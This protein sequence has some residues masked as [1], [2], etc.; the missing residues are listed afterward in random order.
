MVI[1]KI[2][3]AVLA[4]FLISFVSAMTCSTNLIER[5]V[6]VGTNPESAT[7]TCINANYSTTVNKI[8]NFFSLVPT[9]PFLS[10]ANAN[11][12]IQINFNSGLTQNVYEGMIFFSDSSSPVTIKVNVSQPPQNPSGIIVFPTTKF[13]NIKQGEQKPQNIQLIVPSNYGKILTIHSVTMNPEISLINFG[14][15]NLGQVSPG[16]TLNLGF[17][18]DA[19]DFQTGVYNTQINI[20]ATDNEGQVQLPL[21]NVQILVSASLN[22]ITNDTFAQ[23]PVCSLSAV[24]MNVN[25]TYLFTCNN[26]VNNLDI[27][28]KYNEYFEG[29]SSDLSSG[30]YSYKF[31]PIKYGTTKFEAVFLYRNSPIFSAYT[32]EVSISSSGASIP[33]TNLKLL[34][35]PNLSIAKNNQQV[36]IQIIDNRSGSLVNSPELYINA[37]PVNNSISNSFYFNFKVGQ[38]YSIRARSPGYDDFVE[39][40]RLSEKLMT[41]NINPKEGDADTIFNITS[42]V[43]NSTLLLNG[44][45]INNPYYS[46]LPSGNNII[47]AVKEGY[48]DTNIT[49][50]IAPALFLTSLNEFK[51]GLEQTFTLSKNATWIVFYQK[52]VNAI[53][54]KLVEGTGT[55]IIFT[56]TKSGTY[57][58]QVNGKNLQT[59]TIKGWDGKLFN[60]NWYW[61][62]AGLL[63]IGVIIIYRKRNK[64]SED[65]FQFGGT[66]VNTG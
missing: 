66:P 48:L 35:T 21:I 17:T 4:I 23:K 41:I 2:T 24:I 52:D 14:D 25:N 44:A 56:P 53:T 36:V 7:V 61:Y 28:P 34:Y 3:T 45:K 46:V 55:K 27:S 37:L 18:V 8:G 51:K 6:V 38:E 42:D 43:E 39:N 30:I 13:I 15:L 63:I 33:G 60:I 54:E 62:G 32:Q 50:N 40:V 1:K 57:I 59:S 26:A 12:T 20:L 64:S 19:K 58:I 10:P 47:V 9:N 49:I 31:K 22:P 65:G 16:Q 5:N 29:I 11:E